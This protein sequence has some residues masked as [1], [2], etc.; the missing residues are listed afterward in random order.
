M[1]YALDI[2]SRPGLDAGY[3]ASYIATD[4]AHL[5]KAGNVL[6]AE[7]ENVRNGAISIEDVTL[8]KSSLIGRH[9]MALQTFSGLAYVIALDELYGIGY[10]A[11]LK[12]PE[13]ISS[14]TKEEVI[15]ASQEYVDLKNCVAV[16]ITGE[17]SD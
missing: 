16:T 10:D 14:I 8:A 1:A 4:K 11:Y 12:Y 5:D 7:L 3:I 17:K 6:R 9:T 2:I 13:V 15:R